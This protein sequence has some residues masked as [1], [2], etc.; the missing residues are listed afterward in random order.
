[1]QEWRVDIEAMT[2]DCQQIGHRQIQPM[3]PRLNVGPLADEIARLIVTKAEDARLKWYDDGRV[4][5]LIGKII[6]AGSAVRQTLEGRRKRFWDA[7]AGILKAQGWSVVR[8]NV[9][10][11]IAGC[12]PDGRACEMGL[13][14][15][16]LTGES[17]EDSAVED[18]CER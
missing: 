16:R 3:Q 2:A 1:L 14:L 10:R 17:E 11:P 8:P 7:L 5:V 12:S 15:H 18:N 6:P 4:R 9:Y 13:Q